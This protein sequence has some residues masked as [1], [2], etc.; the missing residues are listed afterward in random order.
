MRANDALFYTD[1][2]IATQLRCHEKMWL[3]SKIN[4]SNSCLI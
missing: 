2:R 1:E 3:V 4:N